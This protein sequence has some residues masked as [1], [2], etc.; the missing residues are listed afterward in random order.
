MQFSRIPLL[1]VFTHI[2][3][4]KQPSAPDAIAAPLRK[5]PWAQLNF[6]HTTDSHGWHGGH[7]QEAQ[8]SADWG[9]YV[10]FASHLR[11]RADDDGSDLL[12]IDTGDRVE[13]NGLYDASDPRGKYT[14][15]IFKQQ[16]ID[17]I[18]IGNH[19]L[20]KN[21]TSIAEYDE[22][23]PAY[24]DTYIASNLNI[25]DARD[26]SSA[27]FSARYRKFT[28]KNQGIRILA[29]GFIYNFRGNANNTSIQ[30]AEDTVQEP[31]FQDAIRNRDVDLF[32]IAGHVALRNAT[33]Y[34]TIYNAIRSQQ[35]DTPIVLFGGH[36][37]IRDFRKYDDKAY[38]IESGR[39]METYGFLSIEGLKAGGGKDVAATASPT[40]KR[41]Y[42]DN[43]LYSLQHHTGTNASTFDTDRGRNVS[44]AIADARKALEL[45][46]PFG[47][48]PQDYWLY[49]TQY[50]SK[51]S[52]L[53]LVEEHILPETFAAHANDSSSP[54]I[55]MTNSGALRF[56]IFQG[57]FTIDSTYALCPFTSTFRMIRNVPYDAASKVLETLNA[58]PPIFFSEEKQESHF[59]D[60]ILSHL[61]VRTEEGLAQDE[62]MLTDSM[63]EIQNLNGEQQPLNNAQPA[64]IPGYITKDDFGTEGDDTVHSPIPLYWP[65]NMVGA[66]IGF[67]TSDKDLPKSVDLIYNEYVQ[68]ITLETLRRLGVSYGVENTR[69]ALGGE[70]MTEVIEDVTSVDTNGLFGVHEESDDQRPSNA[71]VPA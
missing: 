12:L 4:S 37:H 63:L 69:S 45:D 55:V 51:D 36:T 32:L 22:L 8:Y 16:D 42:V 7:L 54:A 13:G 47:C 65:P 33:E 10:S 58:G 2:A 64:L 19:E 24:K 3:S 6:L 27:P 44:N 20:Y 5:L 39:Y 43:N 29:M 17:V 46:K 56:D 71:N 61:S 59:N 25:T 62:T 38:G 60:P 21:T 1:F 9:D 68:R 67:S 15:D 11:K 52:L 66:N 34:E 70:T 14:Y 18:T 31:W 48:A 49:R 23:V 53:S 26:G 28:T 50:P 40:Y 57:P 35:W 41:M 30:K